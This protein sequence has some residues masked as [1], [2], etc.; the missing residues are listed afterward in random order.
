MICWGILRPAMS[1]YNNDDY[2]IRDPI[3]QRALY[4]KQNT[5][6]TSVKQIYNK[7]LEIQQKKEIFCRWQKN[8]LWPLFAFEIVLF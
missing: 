4:I 5:I 7:D 1:D 3:K 2:I 8:M 6:R